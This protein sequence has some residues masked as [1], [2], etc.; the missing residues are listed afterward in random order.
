MRSR[1]ASAGPGTP[2]RGRLGHGDRRMLALRAART[3]AG[4]EH[5]VV[6]RVKGADRGGRRL[7]PPMIMC[8]VPSRVSISAGSLPRGAGVSRELPGSTPRE[9]PVEMVLVAGHDEIHAVGIKERQEL[10][11][12]SDVGPVEGAEDIAT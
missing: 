6:R 1:T 12:D 10:L 2:T 4:D 9:G 11:P 8:T 3:D 7:P 5:P